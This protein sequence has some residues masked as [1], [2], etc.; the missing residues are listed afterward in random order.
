MKKLITILA[1]LTLLG[2]EKEDN[3]CNCTKENYHI[4]VTTVFDG[5]GMPHTEIEH[6]LQFTETVPCQEEVHQQST[7]NLNYFNIV[8]E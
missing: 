4:E 5:N 2:C 6:V 3:G 8:C 7:G 1:I